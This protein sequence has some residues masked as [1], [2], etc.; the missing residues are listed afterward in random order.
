MC[1]CMFLSYLCASWAYRSPRK[2][3]VSNLP[4]L[5]VQ[6]AVSHF[7]ST[8]IS[9]SGALT[10]RAIFPSPNQIFVNGLGTLYRMH[11]LFLP[12]CKAVSITLNAVQAWHSDMLSRVVNLT[13]VH[14]WYW[15]QPIGLQLQATFYAPRGGRITPCTRLSPRLSW[16]MGPEFEP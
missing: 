16:P 12:Y 15:F 3:E 6:K 13:P 11:P 9:S 7:V 4:E 8:P 2:L 14:W 10:H 5:E 1:T